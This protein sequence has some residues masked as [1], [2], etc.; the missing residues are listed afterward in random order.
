MCSTSSQGAIG[1]T[2]QETDRMDTL[3]GE[4]KKLK[5]DQE[6]GNVQMALA[7]VRTLALRQSTSN[8][9]LLAAVEN[10][11]DTAVNANNEEKDMYKMTLK[12]CRENDKA[13][14]L[15]GLIIKLVG[16]D[17]AKKAQV[18]IDS[19]KKALKKA[20]KEL[21]E[22]KKKEDLVSPYFQYAAPRLTP[23]YGQAF[24]YSWRGRGRP[25]R[26]GFRGARTC[27]L[28]RSPDHIVATCPFNTFSGG[29]KE[30]SNTL[31]HE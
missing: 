2:E 25:N 17:T 31:K 29:A 10:L 3:E 5:Q 27:F 22:E 11:Y 15:H 7:Q 8:A 13:G 12:A 4:I 23:Q 6:K 9:F 14:P 30:A 20:D 26:G 18:A 21:K 28:C 24:N 16:N 1:T 19:W